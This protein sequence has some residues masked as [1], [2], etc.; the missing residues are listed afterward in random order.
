M[1]DDSEVKKAATEY[2]ALKIVMH[3]LRNYEYELPDSLF[4]R[5]SLLAGRRSVSSASSGTDLAYK[6]SVLR[7]W[8]VA[9]DM[10]GTLTMSL[11]RDTERL[12]PL[13]S[14]FA[15]G[16]FSHHMSL[17]VLEAG[18]SLSFDDLMKLARLFTD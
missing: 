8:V 13:P 6:A 3:G 7:D 16:Y 9:D 2:E 14:L 12:F 10:I 4:D 1:H 11:C 17:S 18:S 5:Q 15:T